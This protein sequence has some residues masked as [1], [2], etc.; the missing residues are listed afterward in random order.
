MIIAYAV[1]MEENRFGEFEF[2]CETQSN[3]CKTLE[4]ARQLKEDT[5]EEYMAS[6][7]PPY[8]RKEALKDLGKITIYK[9]TL[10]EVK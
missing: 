10:E 5:I 8:T 2:D 9:V 6:A 4:S 7:D 3:L 1:H